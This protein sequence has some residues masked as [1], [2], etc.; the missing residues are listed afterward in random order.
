MLK[1]TQ[2]MMMKKL[3]MAS[4]LQKVSLFGQ[5]CFRLKETFTELTTTL[6]NTTFT[7]KLYLQFVRHLFQVSNDMANT[8]LGIFSINFEYF[9]TEAC[10]NY[11]QKTI[12]SKQFTL[13]HLYRWLTRCSNLDRPTCNQSVP[14]ARGGAR[15]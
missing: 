5:I 10:I 2:E 4:C 8:Q 15:S 12:P 7:I 6:K 11:E 3:K 9:I 1:T 13:K 14:H